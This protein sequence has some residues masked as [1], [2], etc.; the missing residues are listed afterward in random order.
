MRC[1]LLIIP[2]DMYIFNYS[3]GYI[4][5]SNETLNIYIHNFSHSCIITSIIKIIYLARVHEALVIKKH[6]R[7]ISLHATR[8]DGR[9]ARCR[10]WRSG[11]SVLRDIRGVRV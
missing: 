7:I 10:S 5:V 8:D 2:L 3:F 9:G 4:S 11:W 6:G 1:Y